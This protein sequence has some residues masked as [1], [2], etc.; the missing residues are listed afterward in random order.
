MSR[1]P[2]IYNSAFEGFKDIKRT[3]I[4]DSIDSKN[5]GQV[6]RFAKLLFEDPVH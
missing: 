2:D 5:F 3:L 1:Q 6:G 4:D